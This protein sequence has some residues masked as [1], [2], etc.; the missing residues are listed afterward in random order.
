LIIAAS[1]SFTKCEHPF[2][3]LRSDRLTERQHSHRR[4]LHR[5]QA[6]RTDFDQD[7]GGLAGH[8]WSSTPTSYRYQCLN[9]LADLDHLYSR[10]KCIPLCSQKVCRRSLTPLCA[11]MVYARRADL[12]PRFYP[13]VTAIISTISAASKFLDTPR[14][15]LEQALRK[16]DRNKRI[17]RK[18]WEVEDLGKANPSV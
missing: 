3:S 7:H 10:W 13:V 5:S 9:C 4:F 11:L 2:R 17:V 18:V 15:T 8:F 1:C 16:R 6:R 14:V 12:V